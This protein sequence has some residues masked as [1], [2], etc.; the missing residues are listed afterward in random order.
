[1]SEHKQRYEY[2]VEEGMMALQRDTVQQ[3]LDKRAKERYQLVEVV[4]QKGNMTFIFE[5][6]ADK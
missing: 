5:R 3:M 4:K 1:M 2:A 6:P